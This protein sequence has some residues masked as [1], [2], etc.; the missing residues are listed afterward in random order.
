MCIG[1][2]SPPLYCSD[3]SPVLRRRRPPLW[4]HP[5]A[6][7]PLLS[8]FSSGETCRSRKNRGLQ[9][10]HIHLRLQPG[11]DAGLD[12]ALHLLGLSFPMDAELGPPP[13][14]VH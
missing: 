1:L 13:L 12:H 10:V 7:D 2:G 6:G 5:S 8:L 9:L 11:Q 3:P 14:V 4:E